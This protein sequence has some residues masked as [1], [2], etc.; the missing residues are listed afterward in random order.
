M[1]RRRR[2]VL[3]PDEW[4]DLP[5]EELLDMR[6]R[7]LGVRIEGSPL[8]QRIS[9]LYAEMEARG[10]GF[11]PPC[12]LADEWLTPDKVPVIGIAFYLCIPGWR[13]SRRK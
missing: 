11:H 1:S 8:E 3:S 5:D 7:D 9:R 13:N 6:V 12:Y 10:I 2:Q 4:K